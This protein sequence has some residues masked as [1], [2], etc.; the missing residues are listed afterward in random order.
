LSPIE[1]SPI[2]EAA[3]RSL[4]RRA[5]E[6]RR[7]VLVVG[8]VDVAPALGRGLL[9]GG[10]TFVHVASANEARAFITDHLPVA[11]LVSGILHSVGE[12]FSLVQWVRAQQRLAFVQVFV[13]PATVSRGAA[14]DLGADDAFAH[15]DADAVICMVARIRHADT[16]AQLALL[17]PLT[18]LHNRRFMNDRLQAEVSRAVRARATFSLALIDLDDF[19]QIN[20][21]YGHAAGDRALVAFA[22]ALRRDL[23]AY[24]VPCRFGGDE[25]VVLFPDRDRAGAQAALGKLRR[26]AGWSVPG[27]PLVTFSAGIAQFPDDGEVWSKLFDVADRRTL[28]AKNIGGNQT[29]LR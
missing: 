16:L 9:R 8:D 2:E 24:D 4:F 7:V 13:S 20:D 14:V 10:L 21:T 22:G 6:P 18:Q 29:S 25:F 15:I 17:D 11:V 28:A 3:P 5:D 1:K 23:R 26:R 12:A 19:K 27:L